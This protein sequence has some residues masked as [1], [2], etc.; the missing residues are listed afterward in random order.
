MKIPDDKEALLSEIAHQIQA[1]EA[2]A[3][4]L[5]AKWREE[6]LLVGRLK[7][8]WYNATGERYD[9]SATKRPE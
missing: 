1:T 8:E 2:R 9:E 4:A 3:E 7:L 5:R 6:R